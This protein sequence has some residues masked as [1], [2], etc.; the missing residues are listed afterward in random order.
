M[1]VRALI[2]D[3]SPTVQQLLKCILEADPEIH[4]VGLASNPHEARAMIK[5]QPVDVITLDVEMP[6]MNGL[7]FLEKLMRLRPMPVVMISSFTDR[8]TKATVEALAMGAFSCLPKPRF[9]DERALELIRLTVKEA[10]QSAAAIKRL[11]RGHDVTTA[12]SQQT[13]TPQPTNSAKQQAAMPDL[14]VIGASTGGVEALDTLLS[15]FP[16]NCPPTVIAQH[17]LPGFT[18]SLSEHLNKVCK[19]HVSEARD[20]GTLERGNVYL[21]PTGKGHTTLSGTGVLKT[22]VQMGSPRNGHMPSV[23]ELFDSAASLRK[24]TISAALLTGMGKDGAKGMLKLR[25]TGARTIAQDEHTSL[26]YGMPR[27]AAEMDAVDE[28]LPLRAIAQ[29][30]MSADKWRNSNVA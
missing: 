8:G 2:V 5:A 9:D 24:L 17:M 19:A 1:S 18:A 10:A 29:A 3:D 25:H 13:I 20:Q 11:A 28:I 7:E 6:N 15:G 23:D 26:I 22:R 16:A 30:L 12:P 21:A 4:V 14:V 27:A